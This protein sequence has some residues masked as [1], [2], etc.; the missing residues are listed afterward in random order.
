MVNEEKSER[1]PSQTIIY[2]GVQ[3]DIKN[4]TLS[5]PPDHVNQVLNQCGHMIVSHKVTRRQL[6]AVVGLLNFA[7]PMLQ[8]GRLLLTPIIIWMNTF[9]SVSLRDMPIQVDASLKEALLPF[10]DRT[11]LETPT[12]FRPLHPSLDISTDAAGSGWSGVIGRHQVQDCWT[13][14]DLS[15]HIN[16]KEMKAILYSLHFIKDVLSNQPCHVLKNPEKS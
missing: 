6:E 1:I 12:S 15:S 14:L 4:M 5:L 10:T 11:F 16:V 13:P 8:L 2:L 3:I 9:S 7:G